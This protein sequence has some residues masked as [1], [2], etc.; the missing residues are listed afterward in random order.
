VPTF[1]E[2]NAINIFGR[3]VTVLEILDDNHQPVGDAEL[4]FDDSKIAV[5]EDFY[6]RRAHRGK[7]H[8][9]GRALLKEIL[10]RVQRQGATILRCHPRTYERRYDERRGA[11]KFLIV[12]RKCQK[13]N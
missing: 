4:S 8:N 11:P 10:G 2:I 13:L 1:R 3:L 9:Y 7:P 5:L 12:L 6:I